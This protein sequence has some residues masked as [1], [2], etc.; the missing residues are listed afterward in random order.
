MRK[1]RSAKVLKLFNTWLDFVISI[2]KVKAMAQRALSGTLEHCFA[3]WTSFVNNAL[4]IRIAESTLVIQRFARNH[5]LSEQKRR[6]AWAAMKEVRRRRRLKKRREIEK[7]QETERQRMEQEIMQVDK[8]KSDARKNVAESFATIF[9]YFELRGHASK[10]QAEAARRYESIA[11][12]TAMSM[13]RDTHVRAAEEKASRKA[14]LLFRMDN[15]PPFACET[16]TDTFVTPKGKSTHVCPSAEKA[17]K[18]FSPKKGMAQLLNIPGFSEYD[19]FIENAKAESS[20]V[21]AADR[22]KKLRQFKVC[23]STGLRHPTSVN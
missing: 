7:M 14:R 20:P 2:R 11:F 8:A 17:K 15:P 12:D 19:E 4:D 9:G 3:T 1:M 23:P 18:L 21:S 16:C 22:M 13:A 10:I 5:V 6:M